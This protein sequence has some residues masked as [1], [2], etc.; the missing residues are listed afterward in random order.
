MPAVNAPVTVDPDVDN[1]RGTLVPFEER[2][3]VIVEPETLPDT[4]R[5]VI[6]PSTHEQ[7][8]FAS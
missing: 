4:V 2:E 7:L 5:V 1:V 8:P 6:P 3:A